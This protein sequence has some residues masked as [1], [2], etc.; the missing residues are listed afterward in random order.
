MINKEAKTA[1]FFAAQMKN[2]AW[3]RRLY[4]HEVYITEQTVSMFEFALYNEDDDLATF[5]LCEKRR[6]FWLTVKGRRSAIELC[7]IYGYIPPAIK[8][9][10]THINELISAY[11]IALFNNNRAIAREIMQMIN[12][13]TIHNSTRQKEYARVECYDK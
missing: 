11:T 1:L 4:D 13:S 9:V 7:S 3:I 2:M 5:L 10:P 8:K 12:N 6:L